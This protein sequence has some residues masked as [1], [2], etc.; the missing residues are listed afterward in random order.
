VS[1]TQGL[2]AVSEVLDAR[3]AQ[4]GP[5]P[6]TVATVLTFIAIAVGTVWASGALQRWMRRVM[7]R[8]G[9]GSDGGTRAVTTLGHYV[10]L[11]SGFGVALKT[12]GIDIGTLFTAGAVFAVGIGFAM[13]NIAQNFVAGVILLV[14]RTIKPGD[15]LEVDGVVVRVF[16]IG[17][18]ST[19]VRTRDG[20]DM[21]VPNALLVQ[22]TV[23]NYTLRDA[24]YRVKASVG[25][26]YDSDMRLVMETLAEVANQIQGKW[27]V[28]D[29]VPQVLMTGFGDNSVNYEV[30]V[31]MSDP[32][33]AR[34][35][36]SEIN[37]AIWWAFQE[38]H[39][40]IAFPQLD[41]HFD[42]PVT[43]SIG[44]IAAR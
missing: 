37:Q 12:I 16:S 6:I 25:V 8:H 32:W 13:Q 3:I 41:V 29:L 17:I 35:A 23:K 20:E 11:V 44:K 30:A 21:I 33:A 40:V 1:W 9:V 31:W 14:E 38:R 5:T 26:T 7:E 19:I 28:V 39:V 18:R 43:E 36:V 24:V 10:L 2:S 34:P 15:I 4:I 27:G 42:S 22:S